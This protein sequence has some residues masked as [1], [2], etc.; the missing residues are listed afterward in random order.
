MKNRIFALSCYW[1]VSFCILI[2]FMLA[3]TLYPYRFPP[4]A[5][6]T[7]WL[8]N[9]SGLYFNGRGIA[10]TKET[11]KFLPQEQVTIEL[12]LKERSGSKNW[13]A[14]DI[15][16]FYDGEAS[17]PMQIRQRHSDIFLFSRADFI[18]NKEWYKSF[19][20][21]K[22]IKKGEVYLL[23]VTLGSFEKAIYF[24]GELAKKKKIVRKKVSKKSSK[25]RSRSPSKKDKSSKV[26]KLIKLAKAKKRRRKR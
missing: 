8:P 20:I 24:N 23:T 22:T 1:S 7:D 26:K 13:G 16:S 9:E 21:E 11:Q 14:K 19:H 5:N 12:L 3:V 15:F 10:Y 25:R 18:K 4:P 17:P 2:A 6:G